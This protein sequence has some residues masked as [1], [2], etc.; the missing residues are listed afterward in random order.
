MTTTSDHNFAHHALDGPEKV[1]ASAP[2]DDEFLQ[3]VREDERQEQVQHDAARQRAQI[4]RQHAPHQKVQIERHQHDLQRDIPGQERHPPRH[5]AL[6]QINEDEVPTDARRQ[7]VENHARP[8]VGIVAQKEPA[9]RPRKDRDEHKVDEQR[10]YSRLDFAKSARDLFDFDRQHHSEDDKEHA[11]LHDVDEPRAAGAQQA[12]QHDADD[13]RSDQ[14]ERLGF[15]ANR[16]SAR[17][18]R[19]H[20]NTP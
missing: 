18:C 17:S 2:R 13:D 20:Y 1:L 3:N 12:V 6:R 14:D 9:H 19:S 16:E 11:D 15:I 4:K 8:K 7:C 5:I 10:E